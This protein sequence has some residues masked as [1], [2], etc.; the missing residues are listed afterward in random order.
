MRNVEH[1]VPWGDQPQEP[2]EPAD[3][4]CL[5]LWIP[6]LGDITGLRSGNDGADDVSPAGLVYRQN[7][8]SELERRVL[9]SSAAFVPASGGF[10]LVV[11]YQYG[12]S[13]GTGEGVGVGAAGTLGHRATLYLGTSG[14]IFFDYGGATNGATRVSGSIST[15]AH[16]IVCIVATT[17]PGG[18]RLY[19]NG[20]LL[21]SNSANPSRSAGG[22]YGFVVGDCYGGTAGSGA[23]QALV[24]AYEAQLPDTRAQE[25]S[26]M[27]WSVV[28]PLG[29]EVPQSAGGGVPTITALTPTSIT[30]TTALQ[31]FSRA[32]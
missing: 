15:A 1:I 16:E 30:S 20:R 2:V 8:G 4:A 28:R 3:D 22:V 9:D 29:I 32:A 11:L 19:A 7:G 25:I 6:G 27:P 23:R 26:A 14:S 21:G 13:L 12:T 17:G 31:R 5:G 10:T 24:G 18:M